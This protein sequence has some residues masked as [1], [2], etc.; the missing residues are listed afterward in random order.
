MNR[1]VFIV[2]VLCLLIVSNS[3]AQNNRYSIQLKNKQSSFYSIETPSAFL[4]S[5]SLERR[6]RYQIPIDS[7]DL[8]VSPE[9]I[10]SIRLS[11]NVTILNSSKWLNQVYIYTTDA[12][13]LS[14]INAFPFVAA[15][16]VIA[17]RSNNTKKVN[18]QFDITETIENNTPLA[19]QN[20]ND[21]Y[22][23]GQAYNQIHIHNGEFLHNRGF[24]GE[25]QLMAITDAGFLN[26]KT[27]A[28]FQTAI[29]NNQI[30]GSWDFY[31]N[32]ESVNEDHPHG[33]SCFSTIAANLPGT[34]VGTAPNASY[35]LFRTEDYFTEYPIE[36]NNWVLAVERADSLGVDVIS[37]SLGYTYFDNGYG[38]YTYDNLDGNTTLVARGADIAAKKG[39]LVVVAAGNT[40]SSAWKYITSPADADS[41]LVVGAINSS[42]VVASFSA[43]GP[44]KDNQVKP[45]V[46][47]IGSGS[48][49]S[50]SSGG[51][52]TGSGTSYA[53]PIMAGLSTCLWQAFPEVNNM[54]IIDAIRKSAH[55]YNTPDTR[56]G[57]GIPD[58]KKAFVGLIKTLHTQQASIQFCKTNLS[59]SVKADSV[60]N[61][62]VER[63]LPDETNYSTIY[64]E[65]FSGGFENRN[66][67][68]EDNLQNLPTGINIQYR[69]KMNIA[70]DTSF[71][72]DSSTVSYNQPCYTY[73]FIGDG[74]WTETTNW[75]NQI[76][77]PT[78]LP[79]GSKIFINPQ[80]GGA[81]ILNTNQ[82][83]S[84][85][86][87]LVV[88]ENKKLIVEG[89]LIMQ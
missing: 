6:A 74:N 38:G 62:V 18:K 53:C 19:I 46:V 20:A 56:F 25:N 22:S 70:S 69:L 64:T 86:A 87:A 8:P 35:Y 4:T 67:S 58:M 27:I 21:F 54:Q 28:P 75:E 66:I 89:D 3:H 17:P 13:A 29:S 85:N 88:L 37:V 65:S 16:K 76:I 33:M 55:K 49:I 31:S 73:T 34:F 5:K 36:E 32:E 72:I 11:G 80:P 26:Y 68:Y 48:T 82:T 57:Y 24:R 78:P 15:S 47:A 60:M 44:S 23:Y 84:T 83:I 63:K 30:I 1:I 71:Y 14:K 81:C 2:V 45:D 59:W 79:I 40:G 39:L 43:F 42:G 77:P 9:Y 61:F 52:T 41:V 7:L 51:T 12:V 50:N 10:D